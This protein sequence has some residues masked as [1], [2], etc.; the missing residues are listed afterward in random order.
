MSCPVFIVNAFSD[1]PF[2]G[3]PAG[4][5]VLDEEAPESWMQSVAAQL[6][7]SETAFVRP[8]GEGD[9]VNHWSIRWFSPTTEVDLCGHATLAS[10]CALWTHGLANSDELITFDS[11][12]RG[13]LH[14]R[15]DG[16][17]IQVDLPAAMPE[18]CPVPEGLAAALGVAVKE[19]WRTM[20][21]DVLLVLDDERA[22]RELQPDFTALMKIECRGVAV[23]ARVDAASDVQVAS[24]FFCP[25]FGVD[26]DPATGSLHASLGRFWPSRLGVNRFRARQL[27]DRGGVLDVQATDHGARVGGVGELVLMGTFLG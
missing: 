9:H 2:T 20:E 22:V 1:G 21:E 24:R 14:C 8:L 3:N 7:I 27:S 11:R 4:V 12:N 19:A 6:N 26:E 18:P 13:Q 23:T 25:L 5:C 10:A 15:R 16:E 17:L